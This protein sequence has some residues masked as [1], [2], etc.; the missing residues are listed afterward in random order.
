MSETY[1]STQF[2]PYATFY[3]VLFIV[4]YYIITWGRNSGFK[5]KRS[6]SS[7]PRKKCKYEFKYV[8]HGLNE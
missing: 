7:L 2:P 1:L 5:V 3:F 8:C 6:T 4:M